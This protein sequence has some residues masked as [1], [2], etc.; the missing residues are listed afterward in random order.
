MKS[1]IYKITN[2]VNNKCYIG[3]SK[4]YKQ[5]IRQ[6][7]NMLLYNNHCNK[8]LQSSYNKYG[9]ENFK[10]ELVELISEEEL[11]T[12]EIHY[13]KLF[14]CLNPFKG[15]NKATE[16][17]NTSGYKWSETSRKKLSD[18]K[19]GM[20]IHPD[21][22]KALIN[23]NKNRIYKKGYKISKEAIQKTIDKKSKPILQ[24]DTNGNFIREWKSGTIA[25]IELK[26]KDNSI[27]ACCKG[28]RAI[29]YNYQW[30]LKPKDK[31]Y[32]KVIPPYK[33]KSPFNYLIF[34][35]LCSVMNIEK[36]E[37]LLENPTINLGTISSLA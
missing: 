32:P 13:I 15:Y 3:S 2:L 28:K 7:K 33:R 16:I 24:Y 37:E 5:R 27:H 29:G 30:F 36:Q 19:K 9:K 17:R 31:N 6:H 12:N 26:V 20:K 4:D 8:H 25:A 11:I 18:T 14:E 35:S 1:G 21:T 10:F 22:L 23:A 34:L